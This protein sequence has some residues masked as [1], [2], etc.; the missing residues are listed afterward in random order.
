MKDMG[1]LHT[2]QL[3]HIS[4]VQPVLPRKVDPISVFPGWKLFL[5]A[6][7]VLCQ[8]YGMITSSINSEKYTV[9][10]LNIDNDV[11][12]NLLRKFLKR[13]KRIDNEIN[14]LP[15]TLFSDMVKISDQFCAT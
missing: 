9:L 2:Y 8:C 3:L 7:A 5:S 13:N 6:S 1:T 4:P 12:F 15:H 11:D 14:S 10:T